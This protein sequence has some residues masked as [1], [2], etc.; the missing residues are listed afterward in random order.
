MLCLRQSF[1]ALFSRLCFY[2]MC[3]IQ[4][5]LERNVWR[6]LSFNKFCLYSEQILKISEYNISKFICLL[7]ASR[8]FLCMDII[9]ASQLC[10]CEICGNV[11]FGF[12][13]L[14]CSHVQEYNFT[15][16][17]EFYFFLKKQQAFREFATSLHYMVQYA[18]NFLVCMFFFRVMRCWPIDTTPNL[19]DQG[20]SLCLG[21]LL[22][23]ERQGWPYQ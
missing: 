8:D 16:I 13:C 20:N 15:Y 12:F 21:V 6:L 11:S 10:F 14:S 22:W 4:Q 19:E 7:S 1:S 3:F 9:R 18:P 2:V 23:P 17:S 5:F